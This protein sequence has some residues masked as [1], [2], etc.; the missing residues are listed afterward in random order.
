MADR[1]ALRCL[2]R[3]H[4]DWTQEELATCIGRSRSFVKKWL[5]R[6]REA[7]PDDLAVL[8]SRSCARKT[9]P[10]SIHPRII[11]RIVEMRES[12]PEHLQRV[13]GPKAL[14]YYLPRDPELQALGVPLP[15]STRTIWK[16]LRK[17]GCILDELSRRRKPL[18][19]REP[20]EEVQMDFKDAST[21]PAD[22]EGKQQHV[23]EVLNFVDAGTSILLHAQVHQDFHAETAFEGVVQFLREYGLPPMLTFDRDPRWVG[24]SSGRDFPSALRRF[25]LCL[26]IQPNICPPQRPDKNPYIERYHR[27]F[28]QECLQ[29][30]R[31][32]TLEEVRVVTEQF[33]HHYNGERPHQGRSCGNHPPRIAHP[34]LPILPPLPKQ[35]DPDC[36]LEARD[37]QAFA[38]KVDA[39]GCVTVDLESYYLK[40]QLAGQHVVLFVNTVSKAFDVYLDSQQIKQVPIKGLRGEAMPFDR[41]VDQMR[42]QARSEARQLLQKKGAARRQQSLWA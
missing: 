33:M 18:E 39:H 5:K 13:P 25:L 26:G 9:P 3:L 38:R 29:I 6:F 24:S 15:R 30:H 1:A 7:A 17:E 42:E 37:G 12:S 22:P 32:A 28:N 14:L 34:T 36:W 35:V 27:A 2:A 10:P 4:P 31:P 16:I 40:Q 41:Y 19:P 20:L 23:V 21:V 8:H 11:Q